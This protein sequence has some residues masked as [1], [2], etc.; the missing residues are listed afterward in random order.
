MAE[1][2]AIRKYSLYAYT[3]ELVID[4]L[5]QMGGTKLKYWRCN[6]ADVAAWNH[7]VETYGMTVGQDFVRRFIL[8]Q[9]NARFGQREVKPDA[10]ELKR[11]RLAWLIGKPAI[12][13]WEKV[14]PRGTTQFVQREIRNVYTLRTVL[15][16]SHIQRFITEVVPREEHMKRAFHST[17]KGFAW[18]VANTT[19]YNHKSRWCA[20]CTFR[21]ACKATLKENYP[22]IY[23]KRGY[24]D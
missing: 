6:A 13:R 24:A 14:S 3:V 20:T 1:E 21:T 15:V 18:C 19:L 17:Q 7:F 9:L 16:Q 8:F 11:V 2:M 10:Y 12:A 4:L 5:T 22:K 23:K